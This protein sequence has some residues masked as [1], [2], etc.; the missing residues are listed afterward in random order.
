MYLKKITVKEFRNI[1][2]SSF[3]FSP[4]INCIT[5]VN[6]SGKTNLLDAVYYLSM[7]KS[8][9]QAQDSLVINHDASVASIK[10]EYLCTD[11]TSDT[12][13]MSLS[14]DGEKVVKI[15]DKSYKRLSDHIG[16]FP[17]VMV[18]PYDSSLIN[19][20]GEE[21]RRFLNMILSQTN[22]EYLRAMQSYNQLLLQRNRLLKMSGINRDLLETISM[23]MSPLAAVISQMRS[24]FCKEILPIAQSFYSK[25]SQGREQIGIDYKSDVE[26]GSLYDMLMS[27]VERDI[28]VKYTTTG[29]QRD[30]LIFTM[31]GHPIRRCGS[32]GQQKSFLISVKLAQFLV[33]KAHKGVSPLLLLD[34]LF[35]KLDIN[36]IESLFALVASNEFGQIFISDTN[37]ERVS[38]IISSIGAMS[39]CIEMSNGGVE[40]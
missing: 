39:T 16:A 15:N 25:L 24:D 32:Q 29:V 30:D 23:Q 20:S 37:R 22:K 17:V 10:G 38:S 36:R 27:S 9:M 4:K 26:G 12:V 28:V 35:D 5:G 21:R 31:E 11:G 33:M 19:E 7:T 40:I 13:L 8:F 34:D 18:S 14:R 1:K 2:S 6:G 3:S